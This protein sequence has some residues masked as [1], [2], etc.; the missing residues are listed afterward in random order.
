MFDPTRPLNG[1]AQPQVPATPTGNISKE[2]FDAMDNA[3]L[4]RKFGMQVAQ[5]EPQPEQQINYNNNP[6]PQYEMP[7]SFNSISDQDRQDII[8][9]YLPKAPA[10]IEPTAPA[11]T[12]TAIENNPSIDNTNNQTE[13]EEDLFSDI[14]GS[15]TPAVAPVQTEQ[16]DAGVE[17]PQTEQPVGNDV[18]DLFTKGIVNAS[19]NL[20]LNPNDVFA[21]INNLSHEDLVGLV[22]ERMQRNRGAVLQ[23]SQQARPQA[24]VQEEQLS[25][26]DK[27]A[28]TPIILGGGEE[29]VP[30]V[31]SNINGYRDYDEY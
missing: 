2:D 19:L 10:V 31:S 29:Q 25:Y 24:P 5:P 11:S 4:Q 18:N 27:L 14:F 12:P 30:V 17:S 15:D 8:N 16:T 13:G 26:L 7:N 21:E 9:S 20:N 1:Q 28:Q 23:S 22:A 3:R 6:S